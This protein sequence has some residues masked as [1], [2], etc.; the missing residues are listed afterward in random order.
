[1]KSRHLLTI[2]SL[3]LL[4]ATLSLILA[5]REPAATA[6]QIITS[7][8]DNDHELYRILPDGTGMKRLTDIP[9]RDYIVTWSPDNQ[10]VYF[11]ATGN[12]T[13]YRM[14]RYG[15]NRQQVSPN[16]VTFGRRSR[17][18][19]FPIIWSPDGEWLYFQGRNDSLLY[20]AS[21]TD[22]QV[23]QVTSQPAT[24]ESWTPDRRWIILSMPNGESTDLYRAH[25]NGSALHLFAHSEYNDNVAMW[26]AD[27]QWL[28]INGSGTYGNQIYRIRSD[29]GSFQHISNQIIS[30]NIIVGLSP[31]GQRIVVESD[32]V[33]YD[34]LFDG[35]DQRQVGDSIP[36]IDVAE[37]FSPDGEWLIFR[38]YSRLSEPIKPLYDKP[39]NFRVNYFRMRPDGSHIQQITHT[40]GVDKLIE[41]GSDNWVYFE[42]NARNQPPNIYRV[43]PD[44]TDLQ[45]LTNPEGRFQEW[46]LDRQQLYFL[47]T[48]YAN[49]SINRDGSHVQQ[50]PFAYWDYPVY[51]V[52][53][54][55]D[56]IW[57]PVLLILIVFVIIMVPRLTPT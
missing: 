10:W 40:D 4:V 24:L 39:K 47:G 26:T 30:W 14:T 19:Q 13:L 50:L 44:S 2:F 5:R 23:E 1:M 27:G 52:P 8:R 21:V 45:Q 53:A 57:N 20:R 15:Q 43:R 49:N 3:A 38:R 17:N 34:M 7:R 18:S 56:R 11:L 29:G 31:D 55:I 48:R 36:Y 37:D 35:S 12:A 46:S 32:D 42:T 22:N 6:W 54:P 28:I 25:P 16:V 51:N 33:V 9:G 41:W